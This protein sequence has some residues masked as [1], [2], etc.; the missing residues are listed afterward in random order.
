MISVS[1]AI[2]TKKKI[3]KVMLLEVTHTQLTQFLLI[4]SIIHLPQLAQMVNGLLGTRTQKQFIQKVRKVILVLL[5]S[6]LVNL[7]PQLESAPFE[8]QLQVLPPLVPGVVPG[9][10]PGVGAS[11]KDGERGRES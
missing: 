4:K 8:T 1:S 6:N 7:Y 3:Q 9:A 2:E 11:P 5:A 10:V